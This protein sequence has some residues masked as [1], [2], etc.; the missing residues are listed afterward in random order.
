MFAS[1]TLGINWHVIWVFA[2]TQNKFFL[3]NQI[4]NPTIDEQPKHG[5]N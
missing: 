4:N 3:G 1:W 5:L 2:N